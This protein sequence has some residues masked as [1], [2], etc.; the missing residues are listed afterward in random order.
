[1]QDKTINAQIKKEDSGSKGHH[2]KTNPNLNLKKLTKWPF[3]SGLFG[4]HPE[5]QV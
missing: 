1:M 3:D 2:Q 5:K 4:D